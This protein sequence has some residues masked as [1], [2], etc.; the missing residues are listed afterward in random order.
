MD[1]V[2]VRVKAVNGATV[3]YDKFGGE[4][5]GPDSTSDELPSIAGHGGSALTTSDFIL[6][7]PPSAQPQKDL[8]K[9]TVQEWNANLAQLLVS[10]SRS[11]R[12]VEAKYAAE[13][14]AA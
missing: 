1:N 8:V 2:T 3:R 11:E 14:V 10:H 6:E 5:L 12:G 7:A 9:A 13:V 4:T